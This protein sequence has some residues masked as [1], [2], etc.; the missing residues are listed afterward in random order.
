[1]SVKY[2]NFAV[3]VV[4]W[5]VWLASR[6]KKVLGSITASSNLFR[7]NLPFP[8]CSMYA[9]SNLIKAE[10]MLHRANRG[11]YKEA[12][13][14]DFENKNKKHKLLLISFWGGWFRSADLKLFYLARVQ[15][16]D[17]R[18][19]MHRRWMKDEIR[20]EDWWMDWWIEEKEE[21]SFDCIFNQLL[22]VP[23]LSKALQRISLIVN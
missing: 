18:R 12:L 20:K 5:L 15:N 6:N 2:H 21:K 1:M 14:E 13:Y 17:W 3:E 7:E 4:V 16:C 10:A 9:H 11:R 23:G 19:S 22:K 8:I